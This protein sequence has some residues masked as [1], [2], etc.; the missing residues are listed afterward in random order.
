MPNCKQLKQE[1]KDCFDRLY[2]ATT[3]NQNNKE[4]KTNNMI[5]FF[6]E[7]TIL[8]EKYNN[9][10]NSFETCV[11]KLENYLDKCDY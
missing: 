7:D 1:A 4:N 8:I 6:I 5:S 2:H 11:K 9:E 3:E 10:K